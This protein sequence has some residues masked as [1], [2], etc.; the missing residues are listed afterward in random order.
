MD[1]TVRIRLFEANG[2]CPGRSNAAA[3]ASS[4]T[5][6]RTARTFKSAMQV[7]DFLPAR[8]FSRQ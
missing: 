5:S 4:R 7:R 6:R 3:R 1:M 2:S 8:K